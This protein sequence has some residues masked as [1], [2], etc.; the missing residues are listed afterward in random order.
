[1]GAV[2]VNLGLS[3]GA[4][5]LTALSPCV[6]PA[7]PII[8]GSAAS[9]R[10]HGPLA[11][12]AGLAVALTVIGVALA[13]TGSVAGLGERG[14]RR[15]A[16]VMLLAAGVALLS[17]RLQDTLS[18]F[19]S[20][21]ASRA[22]VLSMKAGN[23]LGGQFA[24]GA[25]LGAV[26]SPCVGP[27]LGAAVGLAS[28]AGAGSVLRATASMF[29][30]GAGAALPLLATAYASRRMLAARSVLRSTGTTGK[31]VF[32]SVMVVMGGLVLS[33]FDKHVEAAVLAQLPP[34]WIDLLAGV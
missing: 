22:A 8:V 24:I 12:A 20:P 21:L 27:T 16:A 4:G 1:M 7:L 34:W 3:F 30:F 6:L 33:G 28:S 25:L 17:T 23:G 31:L 15:V 5:L 9:G 10:R 14:V 2:L 18:R 29:A 19:A 13:A 32:G 11:I 26:W